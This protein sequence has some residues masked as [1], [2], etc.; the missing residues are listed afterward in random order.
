M[1]LGC[2]GRKRASTD[3]HTPTLLSNENKFK[4]VSEKTVSARALMWQPNVLQWVCHTKAHPP[5][6]TPLQMVATET[7]RGCRGNDMTTLC[8]LVSL[9]D[10]RFIAS[11]DEY[12]RPTA[13]HDD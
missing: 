8:L 12:L 1:T 4:N 2:F 13:S 6:P 9:R 7:V 10:V 3:T 11:R 5:T